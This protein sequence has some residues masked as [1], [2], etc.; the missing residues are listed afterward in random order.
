[1]A[2]SKIANAVRLT[3]S[4]LKPQQRALARARAVIGRDLPDFLQPLAF[5]LLESGAAHPQDFT[6]ETLH[7][8]ARKQR[9]PRKRGRRRNGIRPF[10]TSFPEGSGITWENL[11]DAR[12]EKILLGVTRY[13]EQSRLFGAYLEDKVLEI[14]EDLPFRL[15]GF[16]PVRGNPEARYTFIAH[17]VYN[18]AKTMINQRL[19]EIKTGAPTISLDETIDPDNELTLKDMLPYE[20]TT[21]RKAETLEI[22]R[23][24]FPLLEERDQAIVFLNAYLDLS[25]SQVAER[26]GMCPGGIHNRLTKV[27]PS[28]AKKIAENMNGGVK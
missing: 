8:N 4:A 24:I 6:G 22:L 9:H 17:A 28:I 10:P 15:Q 3:A 27:I 16:T 12:T 23:K 19:R 14:R 20:D 1:M 7:P 21:L 18:V 11:Y 26:L 5:R 25:I 2:E 13:L